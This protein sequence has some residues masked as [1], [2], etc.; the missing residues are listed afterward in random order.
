MSET[1][2]YDD[3]S[4][5]AYAAFDRG[6][7]PLAVRRFRKLARAFP[8]HPPA[9]YML[10]LAAKY[11]LNRWQLSLRHNLRSLELHDDLDEASVWNAA[12]AATALRRWGQV[13]A[14]WA[15]AGIPIPA[16]IGPIEANFG[17]A[18]VRLHPATFGETV[19]A[20]RVDPVRARI[21]NVPRPVTGFRFGDLVL[22]DGASTGRRFWNGER[23]SV[24]NVMKRMRRSAF[25]TY[26]A[27]VHA[28]SE[29]TRVLERMTSE[30]TPQI[31]DWTR[32][33]HMLCRKCSLGIAHEKHAPLVAPGDTTGP[34]THLVAIVARKR[35]HAR[36]VVEVWQ[37]QAPHARGL[38]RLTRP[39]EGPL[40]SEGHAWW[41]DVEAE[42][43]D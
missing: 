11:C 16:G 27:E 21:C 19:W 37:A 5:R 42:D 38:Q 25:R 10:G 28:D 30:R 1:R 3:A 43:G 9:H 32:T 31:E 13:R 17:L 12:I 39:P 41:L 33:V 14:L 23:F 34:R 24:F 22:H 6:D 26:A 15:R 8:D 36:D 2:D 20:Q 40:R 29:A 35:E 7:L 4:V 18:V